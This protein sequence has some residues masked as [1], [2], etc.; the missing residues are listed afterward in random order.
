MDW[1]S[2]LRFLFSK[3]LLL[4]VLPLSQVVCQKPGIFLF[5]ESYIY[6]DNKSFIRDKHLGSVEI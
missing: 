2:T 6:D 1:L 3:I 4:Y 5:H